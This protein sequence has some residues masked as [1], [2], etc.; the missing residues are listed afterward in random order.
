MAVVGWVPVPNA[1]PGSR[2]ITRFACAG[3]S[4]QV[5]TIQ[6]AGVIST[7]SNCDCVSRTQS[8]SGT[9]AIETDAEFRLVVGL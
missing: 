1:S 3:G 4:C 6:N 5:G 8:S 9:G 7:G 2:R